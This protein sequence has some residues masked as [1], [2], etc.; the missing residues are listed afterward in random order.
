MYHR[1][2]R[3]FGGYDMKYLVVLLFSLQV[4]AEGITK[5]YIGEATTT[6][7]GQVSRQPYLIAR[8]IDQTSGTIR[9]AVV[10]YGR[11]C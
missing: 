4:W 3:P 9:E 6:I 11:V 1:T 7:N 5:Y 2:Q 8:T 10:S